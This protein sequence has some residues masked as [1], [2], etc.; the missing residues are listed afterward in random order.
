MGPTEDFTWVITD[1]AAQV[2]VTD[3]PLAIP[4]TNIFPISLTLHFTI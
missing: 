2:P 1:N 3:T 4:A